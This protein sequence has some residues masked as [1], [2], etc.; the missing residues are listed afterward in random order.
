MPKEWADKYKG[1][2]DAG[3]DKVREETFARQKK[4][5]VIPQDCELTPRH[6]EIPAWDDMPEDLKPVLRRAD[7]S[8]RRLPRYTDHHI[9]RLF[10]SLKALN[11]LD[12]TLIYYIIGD[13]GA[14]AEGTLNGTYNEMINFNGAAAIET[15]EF[16]KAKDR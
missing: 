11:V 3:W 14:S 4:L 2:F 6:K 1:K 8:L 10:D 7:G 9:G 13:N 15:A 5:G 16:L 12:D